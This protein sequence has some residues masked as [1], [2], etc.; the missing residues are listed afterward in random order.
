MCARKL[1]GWNRASASASCALLW[2]T[3]TWAMQKRQLD[4]N[5]ILPA[6][7]LLCGAIASLPCRVISYALRPSAP[8]LAVITPRPDE[9]G[10]MTR[11]CSETLSTSHTRCGYA[12]R[13]IRLSDVALR[14]APPGLEPG[15]S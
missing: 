2:A 13:H 10:E 11:P 15:L 5:A 6:W 8:R 3:P 7:W 1:E 12:K 4:A 14:V 9:S